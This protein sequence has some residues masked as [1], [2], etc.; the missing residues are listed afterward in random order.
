MNAETIQYRMCA[1]TDPGRMRDN[2]EDAVAFDEPVGLCVLADGLGG[3]NAGEVASG[4]AVSTVVADLGAWLRQQSTPPSLLAAS[5]ELHAAVVRANAA[6]VQAA[7]ADHR[8]VGMGSTLVTGLFLG[9]RL[10]LGHVGDSR[11]YCWRAG[12]LRQLTR[13]HSYV[14]EQVD[15][16][17]LTPELAATSNRRNL[18]TRA[19]GAAPTVELELHQHAVEP[20]DLYLLC[21]DGLT[22]MLATAA[23]ARILAGCAD[24]SAC[25]RALVEAA[26]EGGGR[27]NVTVLLVRAEP[28]C[29]T[30]L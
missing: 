27:D 18:V 19:L 22:D 28:A 14:Q 24:L 12:E 10:L 21:S 29:R 25:A 11:C 2:N 8:R 5:H 26:N 6:I 20:N 16:G 4:M 23:I 7:Q 30:M 1:H 17:R 15:A 13:D 3:H 9:S